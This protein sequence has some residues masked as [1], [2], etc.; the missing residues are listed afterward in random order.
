MLS[1]DG[2]SPG[3][4]SIPTRRPGWPIG[5]KCPM[6]GAGEGAGQ[7]HPGPG[8]AEPHFRTGGQ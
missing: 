3:K 4:L 6:A 5:H 8:G 7:E 1:N 2:E